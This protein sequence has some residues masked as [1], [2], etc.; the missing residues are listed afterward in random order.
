MECHHP[1]ST[2]YY[3]RFLLAFASYRC[4]RAR[5]AAA[6]GEV[7]DHRHRSRLENGH[8]IIQDRIRDGFVKNSL[9]SEREEIQLQAFHLNAQS[10]RDILDRDRREIRL[11]R[12]GADAGELGEDELDL[13]IAPRRGFGNLSM[14]ERGFAICF[15]PRIER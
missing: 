11:M 2:I 15:A 8:Q 9:V 3:L 5:R 14:I 7:A 6:D 4:H 10:I 1:L 12:H 13:V